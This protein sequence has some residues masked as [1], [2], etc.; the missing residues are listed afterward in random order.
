[1]HV[2]TLEGPGILAHILSTQWF[3]RHAFI[4]L[5]CMLFMES[6]H[7][8]VSALMIKCRFDKDPLP[9]YLVNGKLFACWSVK[10]F[11]VLVWNVR[12]GQLLGKPPTSR[13]D[14]ITLSPALTEHSPCDRLWCRSSNRIR[15]FDIYTGHLHAQF[16]VKAHYHSHLG[17]RTW[18]ISDSSDEQ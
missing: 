16:R 4:S 2:F 9:K 8:P 13:M 17:L 12:T 18:D 3:D 7:C 6:R 5:R 10:D 11:H 15:L 1:M 14:I